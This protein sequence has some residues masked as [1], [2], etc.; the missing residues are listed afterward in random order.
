MLDKELTDRGVPRPVVMLTDAHA[1]RQDEDILEFCREVQ[2][3]QFAE[4]PATSC[5]AQA[6]DQYNKVFYES[7]NKERRRYKQE[8]RDRDMHSMTQADFL[9]E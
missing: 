8:Q 4:P 9:C 3:R 2:I 5:W 6:L 7:Y 1:S